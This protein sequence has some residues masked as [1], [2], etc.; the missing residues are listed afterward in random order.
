MPRQPF[1]PAAADYD[2]AFLLLYAMAF[3]FFFKRRYRLR[4]RAFRASALAEATMLYHGANY[5]RSRSSAR[6][7]RES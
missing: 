6:S 7:Q 3:A 1:T 5:A 4:A 2:A